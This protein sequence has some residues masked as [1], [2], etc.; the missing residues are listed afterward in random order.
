MKQTFFLDQN[1]DYYATRKII[2][3]KSYIN[4]THRLIIIFVININSQKE[5][6]SIKIQHF[7]IY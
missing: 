7:F 6:F 5:N 4:Y 2:A 3:H 1:N